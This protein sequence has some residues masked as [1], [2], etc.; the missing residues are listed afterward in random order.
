MEAKQH[1]KAMG[2]LAEL[3]Q[4]GWAPK[5]FACS[6]AVSACEKDK[7]PHTAV[8]LIAEVQRKGLTPNVITFSTAYNACE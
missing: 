8:V 2:L 6:A 7:Q 5:S 1:R 4:K 3:Q